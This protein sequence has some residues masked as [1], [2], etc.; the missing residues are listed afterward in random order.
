MKMKGIGNRK[1]CV[2]CLCNKCVLTCA[3]CESKG[4]LCSPVKACLKYKSKSKKK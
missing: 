4:R 3:K 2:K 1:G